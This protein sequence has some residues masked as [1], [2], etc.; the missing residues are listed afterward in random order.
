MCHFRWRFFPD[1]VA[2]EF[3]LFGESFWQ[4]LACGYCMHFALM[5]LMK[6]MMT[7]IT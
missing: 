2:S 5:N 4:H 7:I 1:A 6:A 3:T